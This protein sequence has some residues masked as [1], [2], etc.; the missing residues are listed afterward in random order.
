MALMNINLQEFKILVVDDSRTARRFLEKALTGLRVGAVS[1]ADDGAAAIQALRQFPADLAICDLHMTP[2]DG[3]EFTRVMRNSA[4]SPNPY[5][6]VL[7][8]TADAT[9]LQLKNAVAAGVNGF[10]SKPVEAEPLLRQIQRLFS[11]PLVYVH[12]ERSLRP[13]MCSGGVAAVQAGEHADGPEAALGEA[14][15]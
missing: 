10:M 3:I 11:R 8:L 5:L 13:L 4:D 14:T 2:V 15:A 9:E 7:M 6:P 12:D 1:E